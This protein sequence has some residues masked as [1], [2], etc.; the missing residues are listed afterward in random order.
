MTPRYGLRTMLIPLAIL[1]PLL[2][3]VWLVV[4]PFLEATGESAPIILAIAAILFSPSWLPVAW[5]AW[6]FKRDR[7]SRWGCG[8][9]STSIPAAR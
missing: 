7:F 4:I 3:G 6:Q 2:A 8:A 1:P 5:F 9:R